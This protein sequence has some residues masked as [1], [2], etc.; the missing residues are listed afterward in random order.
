M[1]VF[2][3]WC[4]ALTLGAAAL[5]GGGRRVAAGGNDTSPVVVTRDAAGTDARARGSMAALDL[6]STMPDPV[7]FIGPGVAI[8]GTTIVRIHQSS[9]SPRAPYALPRLGTASVQ[10]QPSARRAPPVLSVPLRI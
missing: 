9:E 3:I 6:H 4:L 7:A 2:A 8:S 5:F 10:S 1:R